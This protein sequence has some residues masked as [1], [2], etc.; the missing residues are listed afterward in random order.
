MGSALALIA[1]MGLEA[2]SPRSTKMDDALRTKI[3]GLVDQKP[4]VLFMKGSKAFPQCGFS[5]TVVEILKRSGVEDFQTVN[6]LEDPAV[7]AGMKEYANWATFPQ[8]YV[9]GEFVGG[10]DIVKEMYESGELATVLAPLK[11]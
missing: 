5:A 7:R 3:Q 9:K 4:V 8:L 11:S 10:C 6:I 2:E 1:I